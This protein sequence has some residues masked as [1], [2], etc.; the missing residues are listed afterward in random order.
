M[1][2]KIMKIQVEKIDLDSVLYNQKWL[3]ALKEAIASNDSASKILE[4]ANQIPSTAGLCM[5]TLEILLKTYQD[6]DSK[7]IEHPRWIAD[8]LEMLK[9]LNKVLENQLQFQM[10]EDTK[11]GLRKAQKLILEYID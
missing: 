5:S 10:P 3:S 4:I 11:R 1:S 8:I 7:I 6:V 2:T 9:Q